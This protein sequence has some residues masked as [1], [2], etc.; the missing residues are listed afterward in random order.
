MKNEIIV[1][2]KFFDHDSSIFILNMRA[3]TV[4][5]ISTE[6]VTRIKHDYDTIDPILESFPELFTEHC[7]YTFVHS[8]SDFEQKHDYCIEAMARSYF[9]MVLYREL[10]D[11]YK[12]K[13]IFDA[14]LI[15]KRYHTLVGKVDFLYRLILKNSFNDV[16]SLLSQLAGFYF[17]RNTPSNNEKYI[18]KLMSQ[19]LKRHVKKYTVGFENH[20]LCHAASAYYFSPYNEYKALVF[21]L[22][23]HGDGECSTLWIFNKNWRKKIASTGVHLK[24]IGKEV[25]ICTVGTLYT[26]FTSVLGFRANSDEGKV[27]A[28]A[29]Y[30]KPNAALRRHIDAAIVLNEGE[31]CWEYRKELIEKLFE[32]KWLK[33]WLEEIGKEDFSATIQDWL[34][35]TVVKYLNAVYAAYS[36]DTICF[37]GGVVANVIVNLKVY[38]K[39][40]FTKIYIFPAMGDEGT[41]AGA[42]VIRALEL[43]DNVSW[44]KQ[45]ELPYFGPEYSK[46]EVEKILKNDFWSNKIEVQYL[47]NS[48]PKIAA[49]LVSNGRIIAIYQG[50]MEFGPRALGNRTIVANAMRSDTR[51]KINST[52]KR[53][54][55]FQPFCPTVLE[56]ERTRLFENSFQNKNMS[57]AFRLREKYHKILPGSCHIDGTARPQ[58]IDRK[59]NPP[60]YDLIAEFKK[61]SG[62]GLVINTSF[63]LHGRSIVLSPEDALVDFIDC[64]I[65]ALF[66]EGYLVKKLEKIS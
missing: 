28:L 60:F 13:Y 34:E 50:K 30:G 25:T 39:T 43:G 45:L 12:P 37:S 42:A 33:S 59:D 36:C 64:N 35:D 6:R 51:E 15:Q 2:T 19:S 62:F 7:L 63:N 23:G 3:K 4:F 44:L 24:K 61:L 49:E 55:Y 22:D 29:A 40:N 8:F 66:I 17:V 20:H 54:P 1:G 26:V 41:A 47:G 58:F 9:K 52:V 65:D 31:L 10:V 38:E 14:E 18:R 11:I 32:K 53:R 48:W 5:A 21:V 16:C 46:S 27:E 57:T 56:E